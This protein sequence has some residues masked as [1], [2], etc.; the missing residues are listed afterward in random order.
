MRSDMG[1]A[2]VMNCVT[3]P[4]VKAVGLEADAAALVKVEV[5]AELV[6]EMHT[7]CW[8]AVPLMPAASR[9]LGSKSRHSGDV[10]TT[11]RA[12]DCSSA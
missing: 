1:K 7:K 6:A 5:D 10:E 8:T 9:L 2:D 4:N 12:K 11:P 3:F